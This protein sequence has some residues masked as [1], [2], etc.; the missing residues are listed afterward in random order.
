MNSGL[1]SKKTASKGGFSISVQK[2]QLTFEHF[3][4]AIFNESFEMEEVSLST[5][6]RR[7]RHLPEV[8]YTYPSI[9]FTV[10]ATQASTSPMSIISSGV[11]AYLVGMEIQPARQPAPA[12]CICEVSV[13]PIVSISS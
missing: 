13:P 3:G 1:P 6:L 8:T 10:S 9:T 2:I 5:M 11:C 12:D 4:Y 7:Q